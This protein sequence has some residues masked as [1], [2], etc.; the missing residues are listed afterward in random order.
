MSTNLH[1][2][3]AARMPA[4][5]TR[6]AL[7]TPAGCRVSYADLD[8]RSARFATALLDAGARPG[9]R[10]A[11]QVPK[12][13]EAL[14]LYLACLRAGL[15]YVPLNPAYTAS[16]LRHCLGD[17]R[18]AMVVCD[19]DNL[20]VITTL[21]GEA[22]VMTLAADGTGSL[23][24]RAA[25]CSPLAEGP[26][27]TG[28]EAA[29]LLYTSG[30]TGRPKGVLLTHGNL[31]SNALAL[32]EAWGFTAD[33]VLLH[34]L[35]MFHVHGLFVACHCALLSGASMLFLPRF[36]AGEIIALL[37]RCTVMMGVPT[38]YT[39]LL[40]HPDFTAGVCRNMRLFI[41]GSAPL[42]EDTFR[43][44]RQRSGHTILERYGLSETGM[45]TSNPLHG[46]R[47]AGSVGPPLPGVSVRVTGEDGA[48]LPAGAIGHI[49]VKGPN[50]FAGYWGAPERAA[51]DFTADG[52]FRTGD[53]G[54]FD[55]R[56]Y[57][58]LVGRA[59][60]LVISGG[61]NVYPKEIELVLDRLD[62]VEESAVFGVPH[63]DL[64]EAVTAAIVPRAAAAAPDPAQLIAAAREHLAGYKVPKRVLLLD[65]LPR[66]TMGKVQK[67][68]LRDRYLK[69][70]E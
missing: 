61:Y 50:V 2:L 49:E 53:L 32:R 15:L 9:E 42:L 7:E 14:A 63:P 56:G 44:F 62:G 29:A 40:A 43:D 21:A 59:K 58:S 28:D 30:T 45:N 38:F 27:C 34:A 22:S 23:P 51:E 64:G 67:A 4:D 11:A 52:Y 6:A 5:R 25:A 39:R 69:L 8:D 19:P 17:A 36:D 68:L 24:E 66:N 3:I 35:P 16:E 65:A 31:A 55:A 12:C 47:V 37:P 18:P 10:V 54:R 57:L 46:E 70:Y 20:A 48:V 41:S 33:D 26:P 13:P 1:E 60:D